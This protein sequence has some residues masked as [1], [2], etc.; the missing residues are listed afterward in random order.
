MIIKDLEAK[1]IEMLE[2]IPELEKVFNYYNTVYDGFPYA[3]V[4]LIQA[5]GQKLDTSRNIRSREFG[6][7]IFQ[8]TSIMGREDA[9]DLLYDLA[10]KVIELCDA[11]WT[12]WGLAINSEVTNISIT[13]WNNAKKGKG[14]YLAI[15]LTIQTLL[16]IK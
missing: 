14:L 5:T 15:T 8:E 6:V 1:I 16:N 13:D 9:K 12:F 4:E 10:Q 11:D 2:S 3:G 7:L